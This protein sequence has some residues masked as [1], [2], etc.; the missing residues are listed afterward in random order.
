[1]AASFSGVEVDQIPGLARVTDRFLRNSTTNHN[2]LKMVHIADKLMKIATFNIRYSPL[3]K[4]SS[5][6]S[7]QILFAGD[8]EAP[9]ASRLP[10][11]IDQIN[12]ESP[13][14]IGFQEVLEHQYRDLKD[15]AFFR[16]FTSVGV[17]RDDGITRGEYVPLFW[18]TDK[19]KA[20]SVKHFWLSDQP[21]V[22]GS[23]GW[24]AVR[25]YFST[26]SLKLLDF[27]LLLTFTNYQ[28]LSLRVKPGW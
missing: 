17:G 28:S 21:D 12:W 3:I 18:R 8:G 15:Q 2:L 22:P 6:A 27:R 14:I 11:I 9:W 23:I 19:F 16:T 25:I 5:Q 24:D 7:N 20:L 10:L 1:L 13:D 26:I 4:P